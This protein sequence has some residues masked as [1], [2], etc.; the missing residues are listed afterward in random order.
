MQIRTTHTHRE[1]ERPFS[2]RT[3]SKAVISALV[4]LLRSQPSARIIP[5]KFLPKYT[6]E[7][8]GKGELIKITG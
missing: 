7:I 6:K 8:K 5:Q 1:C 2:S 3:K 4:F